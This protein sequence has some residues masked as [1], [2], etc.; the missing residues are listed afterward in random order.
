MTRSTPAPRWTKP[1]VLSVELNTGNDHLYANGRQQVGLLV[2]VKVVDANGKAVELSNSEVQSIKLIRHADS[3]EVEYEFD[4]SSPVPVPP[5]TWRWSLY[6]NRTYKTLP[7]TASHPPAL[8]SLHSADETLR[9][10]YLR[11]TSL[12]PL[13]VAVQ[14]TRDDGKVFSSN[15]PDLE[16]GSVSL[17]PLKAPQYKPSDYSFK[18]IVIE[19]DPDS[20]TRFDG[21]DYYP[22]EY[23]EN[24][25]LVEFAQHQLKVS[26]RTI[27]RFDIAPKKRGSYT[28][29]TYPGERMF[30]WDNG[31]NFNGSPLT[32]DEKYIKPGGMVVMLVR[33][34]V[35]N[36]R[37][38]FTAPD[39]P[40]VISVIDVYGND[41]TVRVRF[42]GRDR[43]FLELV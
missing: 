29:T 17:T 37:D 39:E 20:A 40:M 30:L 26:P 31:F 10:V 8:D 1:T 2:K 6:Y 15:N 25:A 11:T 43:K 34:S 41:H 27:F 4:S 7:G 32:L 42:Q 3:S 14:V 24:G 38:G 9:E 12:K 13:K 18:R 5:D 28:S 35:V 33:R 23:Y 21:H 16:R 19:G 22:L 36:V